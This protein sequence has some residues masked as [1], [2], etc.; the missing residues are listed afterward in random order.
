MAFVFC[1]PAFVDLLNRHGIEV[2]AFLSPMPDDNDE[3]CFLEQVE[4]LGDRLTRH[5]EMFT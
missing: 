2:V 1:N 4:V 3:I 5:V